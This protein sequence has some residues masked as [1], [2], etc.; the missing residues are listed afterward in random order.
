IYF[1]CRDDKDFVNVKR[2]TQL[3]KTNGTDRMFFMDDQINLLDDYI[4]RKAIEGTQNFLSN[5]SKKDFVY[6]I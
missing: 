5:P 4:T 2:F 3:S 1:K 6:L